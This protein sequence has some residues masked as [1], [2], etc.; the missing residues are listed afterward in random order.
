[1]GRPAKSTARMVVEGCEIVKATDRS[2]CL[3]L[4]LTFD[5]VPTRGGGR[6]VPN[7]SGLRSQS[8]QTLSARSFASICMQ[9]L[10]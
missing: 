3:A 4:G 7:L 2:R 1:M 10:P 9:N 6:L 5:T 8:L